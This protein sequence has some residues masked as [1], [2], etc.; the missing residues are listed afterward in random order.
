MPPDFLDRVNVVKLSQIIRQK[1]SCLH[2]DL[3]ASMCASFISPSPPDGSVITFVRSQS[4]SDQVTISNL[5]R[6]LNDALSLYLHKE[7]Y[8]LPRASSLA[9]TICDA[10]KRACPPHIESGSTSVLQWEKFR[11]VMTAI[12]ISDALSLP[13]KHLFNIAAVTKTGVIAMTNHILSLLHASDTYLKVCCN[14]IRACKRLG[15][16]SQQRR[17][18]RVLVLIT[19]LGLRPVQAVFSKICYRDNA[20][21][22]QTP[23]LLPITEAVGHFVLDGQVAAASYRHRRNFQGLDRSDD[24]QKRKGA[25]EAEKFLW[26]DKNIR[27]FNSDDQWFSAGLLPYI[28]LGVRNLDDDPELKRPWIFLE[29]LLGQVDLVQNVKD[30]MQDVVSAYFFDEVPVDPNYEYFDEMDAVWRSILASTQD[31]RQSGLVSPEISPEELYSLLTSFNNRIVQ[32]S[33]ETRLCDIS[34]KQ[35]GR[36]LPDGS[37]ISALGKRSF[38][39]GDSLSW[40]VGGPYSCGF[41]IHLQRRPCDNTEMVNVKLFASKDCLDETCKQNHEQAGQD[42]SYGSLQTGLIS[43]DVYMLTRVGYIVLLMI[44]TRRGR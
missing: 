26:I 33:A 23:M 11:T 13:L 7:G 16:R 6:L 39:D 27:G 24:A 30:A 40:V 9:Y 44:V 18:R 22:D 14:S 21:S 15:T 28:L 25:R 32:M 38:E 2:L 35:F 20:L 34:L 36:L 12:L 8:A 31:I 29:H 4:V 41:H 37:C 43:V 42:L 5:W 10:L 17:A 1:G 3:L 19:S